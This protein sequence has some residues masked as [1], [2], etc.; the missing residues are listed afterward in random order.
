VSLNGRVELEDLA[1]FAKFVFSVWR[2][3]RFLRA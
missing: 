1:P 3:G 2:A